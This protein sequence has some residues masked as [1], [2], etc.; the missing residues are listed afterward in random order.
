MRT[1]FWVIDFI[2]PAAMI[3][4]GMYYVKRKSLQNVSKYSGFRTDASMSSQENWK[5]AHLLAGKALILVGVCLAMYA[6]IIKLIAPISA[7]WLSLINNGIYI[8]AYI[9]ITIGVNIVIQ[10]K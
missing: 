8:L 7:E 2:L 3:I 5:K 10:K 1:A 6:V 9:G 4:L